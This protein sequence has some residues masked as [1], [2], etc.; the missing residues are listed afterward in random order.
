MAVWAAMTSARGIVRWEGLDEPGG[1]VVPWEEVLGSGSSRS[2]SSSRSSSSPWRIAGV[3]RR[4]LENVEVSA[5]VVRRSRGCFFFF[6]GARGVGVGLEGDRV[7]GPRV[8]V[9]C[10]ERH[11]LRSGCNTSTASRGPVGGAGRWPGGIRMV[12]V[13]DAGGVRV[14][15]W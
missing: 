14:D 11:S 4:S 5:L 12:T 7:A 1:G 15:P 13:V 9:C 6:F 3:R 10:L 2:G 8:E